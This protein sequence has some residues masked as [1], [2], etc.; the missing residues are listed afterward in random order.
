MRNK[1]MG[2]HGRNQGEKHLIISFFPM[3]LYIKTGITNREK[4]ALQPSKKL[5][6]RPIL[7]TYGY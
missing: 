1:T 6:A 2:R 3:V 4:L 5:P 7:A